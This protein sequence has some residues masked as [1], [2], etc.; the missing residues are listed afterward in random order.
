MIAG[1]NDL[2]AIKE[3]KDDISK[4]IKAFKKMGNDFASHVGM[5]SG[6]KASD[7]DLIKFLDYLREYDIV[8]EKVENK[9]ETLEHE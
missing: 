2:Q 6:L 5:T 4:L 3:L 7:E 1:A 9:L 8:I